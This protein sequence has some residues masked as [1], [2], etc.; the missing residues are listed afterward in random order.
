MKMGINIGLDIG[1]ISL[2]LAAL[3]KPSDRPYLES[4]RAARPQFQLVE[5]AGRPL[6]LS[7]YRRIAG[8]PIQATYDLLQEFYEVIPEVSVEGIRVTGSGSRT[9]AKVLGLFFENEFKAIARMIGTVYPK[10]RTVFEIGGESSKYIRLDGVNIID[11]DR[12]GECAAGTGS[13]LDQQALRMQYSVEEIGEVVC[14]ASC[15]A[16]IAG[17]CS[18]FA[19]SDMIHA[20]QKGYSPAEILRG[21]CDAVARNFKGSIVKGR[22][23]QSPVALIGAVSQNAGVTA[24]LREAFSLFDGDLFVPEAYAWCGAIGTAMLESEERRKRSILEI[25]RLRQHDTEEKVQDTHPLSSENVVQ[26][27][28]RVGVY[29]P[30]PGDE[31]I[32]AYLGLDIGSVSTNVVAIDEFGTVIH[33]VYLRTSGRPIEAAQQGLEEVERIWGKRL[34]VRGVGTTGSGRE[35]IAEF[36]GA[37][38]VNDEI[39]AHKTGAVHISS[40]L[41]GEQ[42]DTIFEIG[43]QDSKFISIEHGVVVDFAMNEACAAGTGSFLEEQAEKLGISIKGEFAKLALS[44]PSPTRLGERC[45]VFMERDVTGWLNKAETVPN[46]VAGLAYS[47]ALNYLNRVVRGRKI[48]NVIYFQGGTA[49]NDAVT[50]AFAS[51]LGKKITVPPY[52][53]VMGAIGMAL[54]A[55]QWHQATGSQ[56]RFRGY[57]LHKLSLTTRDFVCKACSNL[58]DMKEFVIEGHKSYWGDKCSDK[59][60]KPSVSGRKPVIDDLFAFREQLLEALPNAPGGRFRVGLPRAMSMLERLPFWRRYFADLGLET[61]LS[62]VTDPRISAAGI[63][64][65]VAQP[66]YPVQVAHGH[67]KALVDAG[68]DYVLVPN[69]ADSESGA[70]ACASHYCPWNQTLPWVLRTAPALEPHQ[71]KFLIPT[72]HFQLGPSQVKKGLSEAMSRIGV[73]Q[74][75]SDSAVDAAYAEQRRFQEK[76]LEAGR[77]ALAILDETGEPGLVLAGRGYNIY[78]RGV[79]CDIPRKLRHRYG[80]NVIPLDF[81]VSGKEPA[82]GVQQTMF[83]VSGRKILEAAR[84]AASRPNLHLVYITNFKCGPDSYIKHFA[85]EAAGAPLLILQFDGH[86]NDAG[87]MTRC[88]A[89]L[90][91]KGILRCYQSSTAPPPPKPEALRANIQ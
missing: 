26:L 6:L 82:S 88:E 7:D 52:N 80:A 63:E 12:S 55:R 19:K 24:A 18:V 53:G 45:T 41:G 85:R 61:V 1:A 73:T 69:I 54:I 47:I 62:P 75:A 78:D 2:K 3:G 58:C 66:C 65:A 76:L 48:G 50:A 8:S 16:R 46:L 60:R 87:Y 70:D 91:S 72:L 71:H 40:T 84:V 37:D 74:R 32:P 44:A 9:I 15:A 17:R 31:P 10:V 33:D 42:V 29:V 30:P 22:P 57:D 36:V 89:Y 79:N 34:Q 14:T 27:R 56:S 5:L 13:F 81:L 35:L 43:G 90:D 77:R 39:T 4:L 83:W 67:V 49:Y 20:Q 38:V 23:V 59:F 28:D 51:L 11:Y 64:M 25:H 86:G 21:L 68:V